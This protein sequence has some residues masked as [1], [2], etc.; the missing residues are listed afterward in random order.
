MY[1]IP[2]SNVPED[3]LEDYEMIKRMED[4]YDTQMGKKTI[5]NKE[6]KEDVKELLRALGASVVEAPGEGEALCALMN[7]LKI[8]QVRLTSFSNS[9]RYSRPQF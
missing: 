7:R 5:V 1:D 6:D 3:K 8:V 2:E 4:N 9:S